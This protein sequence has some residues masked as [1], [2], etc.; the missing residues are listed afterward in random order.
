MSEAYF[1]LVQAARTYDRAMG[2]SFARHA[3]LTIRW[4]LLSMWRLHVARLKRET[5]CYHEVGSD[6]DTVVDPESDW[7]GWECVDRALQRLRPRERAIFLRLVQGE[8]QTAIATAVK[9]SQSSVS[10][11]VRK[12]RDKLGARAAESRQ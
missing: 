8:T 5:R 2:V 4:A 6:R 1:G 9:R 3:A 12:S 7:L 11:T 10:A